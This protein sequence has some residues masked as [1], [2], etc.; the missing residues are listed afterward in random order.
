MDRKDF[1]GLVHRQMDGGLHDILIS[2]FL[3]HFWRWREQ[4]RNRAVDHLLSLLIFKILPSGKNGVIISSL[5]LPPPLE[6]PRL[7][8]DH[9]SNCV[10]RF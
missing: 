8:I 1:F 9:P 7:P 10:G 5:M 4:R 2:R 3:L 6:I